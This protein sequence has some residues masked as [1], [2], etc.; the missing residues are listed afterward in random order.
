MQT[1]VLPIAPHKVHAVKKIRSIDG[2]RAISIS[3]VLL[4]HASHSM[5]AYLQD[6]IFFKFISNGALGVDIFFVISGYLITKLMLA[7]ERK[8]GKINIKN[9]YIR[10]ALRIF[11]VFYLYIL[12]ILVL[13]W[14][15]VPDIFSSY[16]LV[17]FAG[18]YLWNYRSLFHLRIDG[19]D[20]GLWFFGH[21]W[22]I[23]ME[24]QF[25]LLWPMAF[26]NVRRDLLKRI[27][28][29]IILI[30]P[31]V[32]VL[33]YFA[34]PECRGDI[35][36]MLHTGGDT[37]LI[38]CLGALIED[39]IFS[40]RLTNRI[41]TTNYCVAFLLL[42]VFV[43]SPMLSAKFHGAYTLLFGM[44]L[45]NVAVLFLL[46]WAIHVPSFAARILNS[47]VLAH[48]GVL[49]Y[50]LYIWQQLILSNKLSYS[51]SG[52]PQ[53]IILVFILAAFSYYVIEKPVLKLK[54]RFKSV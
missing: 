30:M 54:D 44:G 40:N 35:K 6:N 47:K 52:F 36:L 21:F 22:S 51:F 23:S 48:I 3:M 25:Y 16:G 27:V 7:E 12:V 5:P 29:A 38:G 18:L 20:N 43:I 33:T 46:L 17:L 41:I 8:T 14:F 28:L 24:E 32:R 19:N 31:I 34:M 37:I 13:K 49:S 9:F 15:F 11:P 10:R 26:M 42:F 2:L 50:S 53:N 39:K 4:G 1:Q 45:E